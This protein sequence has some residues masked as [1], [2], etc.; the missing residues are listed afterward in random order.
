MAA[1]SGGPAP[2]ASETVSAEILCRAGGGGRG[3]ELG[4]RVAA[5]GTHPR[6]TVLSR[7]ASSVS[8]RCYSAKRRGFAA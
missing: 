1:I 7:I 5:T 8:F 4:G 3:C 6:S 2:H